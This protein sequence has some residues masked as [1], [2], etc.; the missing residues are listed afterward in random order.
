MIRGTLRVVGLVLLAGCQTLPPVEGTSYSEP[1]YLERDLTA[2]WDQ[3]HYW[4]SPA[5]RSFPMAGAT[6]ERFFLTCLGDLCG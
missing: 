6:T 1:R 5:A 3:R 4:R 2:P